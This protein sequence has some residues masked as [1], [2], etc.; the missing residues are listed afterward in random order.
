MLPF[1]LRRLVN[2]IPTVIGATLLIFFII[3]LAPGDF[4]TIQ[5]L[6]P[7]ISQQQIDN[8]RRIYGLDKPLIVQYFYW[9]KELLQGNLGDSFAYKQPVA[10]VIAPRVMNSLYLVL[11]SQIIFYLLA[12]P[13]GVYGAVRQYSLG[14]KVSSTMMYILL[15]F[16]TFFLAILVIF[17]ILQ[18]RFATGWDIPVGGM[19][20]NNYNELTP[21]GKF[22]DVL[23][24][25]AI[26]AIVL[27]L[28]TMAG[29]TRVL[30]GQ[31]LEYMN[32]DFVRT[33]RSKGLNEFKVIYKH[34]LRNAIIPFIAG[35]GSLLPALIGGAGLI[36]V[37]FSYPGITPMLLDA[38]ASRDLY[39]LAGFNLVSIILLIFGNLL[40]DILLSLVDPRI[41]YA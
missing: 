37:V 20:S 8:L 7:N 18:V 9:M 12:I 32:S 15:G 31:M 4:L 36:E 13:L 21:F 33:A 41:R 29:F 17:V 6:D 40:S 14:D 35:I 11:L 25:V 16:P 39:V 19:T 24:H 1:M 10:Q 3:S 26:P 27:A 5:L 22:L 34:T 28:S 23:K 38:L 2:S 30:R